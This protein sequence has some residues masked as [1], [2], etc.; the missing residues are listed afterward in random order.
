MHVLLIKITY[1]LA[2][3]LRALGFDFNEKNNPHIIEMKKEIRQI[4][5]RIE[6]NIEQFPDGSWV[7]ESTNI[8]G[9]ITGSKNIKEISSM[10]KDAIFTY[11]GVPPYLCND[12]LL[13]ADNEPVALKQ[14]VYA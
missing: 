13:K 10:I 9:I 3:L 7:A 2:N 5:G 6:F 12:K 1:F 8:D 4:G 11:F 14:C